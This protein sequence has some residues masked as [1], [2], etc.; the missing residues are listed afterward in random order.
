M[1]ISQ[2]QQELTKR[3]EQFGD[4]SIKVGSSNGSL[5]TDFDVYYVN[6]GTPEE[7]EFQLVIESF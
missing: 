3:L 4:I 6:K 1:K 2:L 5:S 7:P